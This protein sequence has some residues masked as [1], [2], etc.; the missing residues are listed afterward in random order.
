MSKNRENVEN[1]FSA[2]KESWA[3]KVKPFLLSAV[4][5][6]VSFAR[7]YIS[8]RVWALGIVLS[9][10]MLIGELFTRNAL[11]ILLIILAYI[12]LV[13]LDKWFQRHEN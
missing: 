13:Y 3:S 1:V 11:L 6:V 8:V 2:K 12:L 7:K 9:I 10:F 5:F 4:R